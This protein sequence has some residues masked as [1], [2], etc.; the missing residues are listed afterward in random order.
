MASLLPRDT[1][2]G[3]SLRLLRL[4]ARA[5]QREIAAFYPAT[6]SW[7]VQ[8]EA[9]PAGRLRRSTVSRYMKA[10]TAARPAR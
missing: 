2:D 7:I 10:L 3:A 6:R 4:D 1:P 9:A 8:I 5:Y